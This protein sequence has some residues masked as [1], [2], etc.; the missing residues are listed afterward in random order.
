[1]LCLLIKNGGSF[2][3]YVSHN[4]M[5]AYF[6]P[7][8][9]DLPCSILP[10]CK[11]CGSQTIHW[12]L[13]VY[14]AT[15][16]LLY[17]TILFSCIDNYWAVFMHLLIVISEIIWSGVLRMIFLNEPAIPFFTNRQ[18]KWIA[19]KVVVI[20][21]YPHIIPALRLDRPNFIRGMFPLYIMD[22]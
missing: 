16:N 7:G 14:M 22:L 2:H 13:L 11:N 20:S 9:W 4:Q 8:I 6:M 17:R 18:M 15:L 5:V 19:R 12:G 10:F 21:H 3:G 1:M